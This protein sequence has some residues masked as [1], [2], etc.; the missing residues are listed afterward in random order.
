VTGQNRLLARPVTSMSVPIRL[1]AETSE[2][3]LRYT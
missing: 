1:F 3:A 2:K